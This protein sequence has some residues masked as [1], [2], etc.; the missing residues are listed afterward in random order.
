MSEMQLS[1][2]TVGLALAMSAMLA[3]RIEPDPLLS[4]L[5]EPAAPASRW[6]PG[7]LLCL[8]ALAST[9]FAILHPE[10]FAVLAW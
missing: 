3:L 9:G 10:Q 1:Q 2:M 4:Y 5:A 7:G 8:L 6:L